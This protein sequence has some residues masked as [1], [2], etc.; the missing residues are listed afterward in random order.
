MTLLQRLTVLAGLA[1]TFFTTA[2]QAGDTIRIGEINSYKAQAAILEPYRKGW[3]LA[4]EQVN[5]AGGVN[6]KKVEVVWRDDGANPGDAVRSAEDLLVRE[7][8]DLLM[9]GYLSHVGVALADFAKQRK[10][11]YLASHPLSDRIVLQAGNHYTFRLR[12]STYMLSA[13]L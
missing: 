9:G 13:M 11:V 2:A 1:A 7:N 10:V 4:L 5:A 3:E 6:G 12:S 8:V